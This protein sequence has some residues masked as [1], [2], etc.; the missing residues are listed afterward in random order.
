MESANFVP[1]PT[2]DQHQRRGYGQYCGVASALDVVGERW[3][4]LIVRDLLL[5]PKRY[6]DLRDGLPGIATDLLTSRLRTLEA[7]GLVE[8]RTLPRPAPATVYE[9]TER[10]RLLAPVIG[11]LARVGL[12]FLEAPRRGEEISPERLVLSLNP[13]FHTDAELSETY[14]LDLGDESFT[15]AVQDGRVHTKRGPASDPD[16]TVTTDAAT[17]VGLLRGDIDPDAATSTGA[18]RLDGPPR[19]L[20]R[21]LEAFAW[22]VAPSR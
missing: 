1:M 3:T 6:T 18:V 10:G 8:R 7:A 21:F 20:R 16:L 5:G 2:R 12:R 9:L 22:P 11:G 13:V 19:S 4:L 15:V 17:L 14:Q